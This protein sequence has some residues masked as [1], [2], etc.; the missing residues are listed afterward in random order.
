[1]KRKNRQRVA[2][3]AAGLAGVL[4]VQSGCNN[5]GEG[6]LSGAALG[7]LAGLG[8][9]SLTGDAGK[10]AAAGAIIGGLGGAVLGDQNQRRDNRR[11][12]YD[13]DY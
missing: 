1:M 13:D 2:V 5:A 10:G 11:Y 3:L 12:R 7:S 6:A 9:G 4:A 8:L